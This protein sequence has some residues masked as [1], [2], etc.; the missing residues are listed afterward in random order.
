[1]FVAVRDLK[2]AKGR[3]ALMGGVVALITLLVVML[4]ALTAGLAKENTSAVLGLPGDHMVFAEPASG[5]SIGFADSQIG[6]D[7]LAAWQDAP[8]VT[9]AAPLQIQPTRLQAGDR[10]ASV[11]AFAAPEGSALPPEQ[12][13]DGEVLL[14]EE[15][16]KELSLSVGDTVQIS[17][18]ETTVGTIAG[19]D[20]YSH[21]PVAWLPGGLDLGVGDAGGL[22]APAGAGSAGTSV[23]TPGGA[24]P[25]GASVLVLST[26]GEVDLDA[27]DT[28]NGTT[29][30]PLADSV[31]A[32]ASYSSENGS[33]QLMR[34]LLL[35][36]SA[37]VIGAFFT[38]WTV[39]RRGEIAVLKAVGAATGYLVRD[40]VGQALVLLL[41]GT[42]I[43]AGVATGIGALAAG[44]VPFVLDL[45][46]V[47]LP[48]GLLI[49]LGLIG[50][51]VSLKQIT[52]VDPLT[53]LGSA[54]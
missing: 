31:Q 8:G 16:A 22:T 23:A 41:I 17:G 54:G 35:L 2:F 15:L 51:G 39:Q 1:M 6:G 28:T 18:Q 42:A 21:M 52:S 50:A 43:G 11:A 38:V 20:S 36:I 33:L 45:S 12:V 32:L 7:T 13:P 44:A 3:F 10:T 25:E 49:V 30:V 53:A 37:L 14:P 40:A 34:G 47:L 46:T 4:S 9:S 24:D 5:Q 48:V 19:D 26:T 29:T 27:V